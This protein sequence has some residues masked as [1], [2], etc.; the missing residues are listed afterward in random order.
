MLQQPIMA[1]KGRETR[2]LGKACSHNPHEGEAPDGGPKGNYN[3]VIQCRQ[4]APPP[5]PQCLMKGMRNCTIGRCIWQALYGQGPWY[6]NNRGSIGVGKQRFAG[7]RNVG[8]TNSWQGPAPREALPGQ[9][10]THTTGIGFWNW[11]TGEALNPMA[12]TGLDLPP[13]PPPPKPAPWPAGDCSVDYPTVSIS[14]RIAVPVTMDDWK[15]LILNINL[16]FGPT[17][18]PHHLGKAGAVTASTLR[19]QRRHLFY[20]EE[21]PAHG[22]GRKFHKIF[23]TSNNELV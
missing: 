2:V 4:P 8:A 11:V 23:Y 20:G 16:E 15:R 13:P 21:E 9:Y 12:P 18:C 22:K 5:G 3:K 1:L 7:L 14:C 19:R 6:A 10:P 17:I